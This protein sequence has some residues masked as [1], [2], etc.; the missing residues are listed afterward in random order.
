MIFLVVYLLSL[1]IFWTA[2][3]QSGKLKIVLLTIVVMISSLF[4]GLRNEDVGSDTIGYV[5]KT[6]QMVPFYGNLKD[7]WLDNG[8]EIGYV[9]LNFYVA[10][11][12]TD[13][14]FFLFIHQFVII[15]LVILASLRMKKRFFSLLL[16]LAYYFYLYKFT[17]SAARQG[18]AL[19]F[20]IYAITFLRDN[21][22][23]SFYL[24]CLIGIL[25]HN[26][27]VFTFVLPIIKYITEKMKFAMIFFY[28]IVLGG[29]LLIATF[30]Q[31]ILSTAI[32]WGAL[33]SKYESYLD[34]EGFRSHKADLMLITGFF[35]ITI[36]NRKNINYVIY[37][38]TTILL[39]FSLG[40]L[41]M[42]DMIETANRVVYYLSLAAIMYAPLCS[43]SPNVQKKIVKGYACMLVLYGL[44]HTVFYS[45]EYHSD[46]LGL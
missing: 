2:L 30:Y 22:N 8:N 15:I 44:F 45:M 4:A 14:H 28:S 3:S 34:Q 17:L 9:A 37:Y 19:A 11:I 12:S 6:W 29:L 26:S 36:C 32:S 10:K 1:S 35:I 43:T 46:I 18:L 21:K 40:F 16:L 5:I 23:K 41:L 25:F 33:S 42:G 38:Y 7:F 20:V 31:S 24:L 13:F 39:I 27:V